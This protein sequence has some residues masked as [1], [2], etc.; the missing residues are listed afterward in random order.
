MK[1]KDD[2]SGQAGK[3][4]RGQTTILFQPTFVL[5]AYYSDRNLDSQNRAYPLLISI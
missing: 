5:I 3:T 2:I 4:V 1:Y